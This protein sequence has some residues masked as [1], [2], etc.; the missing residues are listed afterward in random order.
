MYNIGLL[1]YIWYKYVINN[2]DYYI[3]ISFHLIMIYIK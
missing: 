1:S 3:V 2:S